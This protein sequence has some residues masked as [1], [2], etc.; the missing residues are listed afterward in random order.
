[1]TTTLTHLSLGEVQG[2]ADEKV[3]RFLGIKYASIK[4][5][6]APSEVVKASD[7]KIDATKLGYIFLFSNFNNVSTS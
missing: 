7:G 2:K 5:I 1:M 4:D 3:A 6:F